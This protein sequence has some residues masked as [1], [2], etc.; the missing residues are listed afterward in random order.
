MIEREKI[1]Q[2]SEAIANEF[3][4]EKIILFGSYAYGNPQDDSDVDMLVILPYKGSNF[5]K[6]WE[7]LNKV[8]PKFA[9]DLVVRSPVEVEQ[10]R[11]WNDFFLREII[12]KGKVIY[13]S[14]NS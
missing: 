14:P 13:E 1:V 10:R 4:P 5:R 11:A 6:S 2:L 8:Q 3:Q 12:E 7:I 9:L